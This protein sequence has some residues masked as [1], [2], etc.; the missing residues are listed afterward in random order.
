MA[1]E[2]FLYRIREL[3]LCLARSNRRVK[4][5]VLGIMAAGICF[6]IAVAILSEAEVVIVP[7]FPFMVALFCCIYLLVRANK[8]F[9]HEINH[10]LETMNHE[11]A[12]RGIQWRLHANNHHHKKQRYHVTL[13]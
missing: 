11:L 1:P 4:H 7:I 10:H 13:L 3:N 5:A 12:Q 9:Q 6:G 2:E 8:I